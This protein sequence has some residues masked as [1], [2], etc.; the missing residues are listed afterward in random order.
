[1]LAAGR[2]LTLDPSM[3]DTMEED[4]TESLR[5]RVIALNRQLREKE[6]RYSALFCAQDADEDPMTKGQKSLISNE[7]D[8][9][10]RA[11]QEAIVRMQEFQDAHPASPPRNTFF[12]PTLTEMLPRLNI[13][14]VTEADLKNPG[15]TSGH[16]MET[17]DGIQARRMYGDVSFAEA[18]RDVLAHSSPHTKLMLTPDVYPRCPTRA[19]SD[20]VSH[21]S[22]PDDLTMV[23]P[24][25]KDPSD[26]ALSISPR[27]ITAERR[28]KKQERALAEACTDLTT[29]AG[30]LTIQATGSAQTLLEQ[31]RSAMTGTS[32]ELDARLRWAGQLLDSK[33]LDDVRQGQRVL[34]EVYHQ[35]QQALQA[36]ANKER[37]LS[38]SDARAHVLAALQKEH[39]EE[40]Q[41]E[42]SARQ[43]SLS[44]RRAE[45]GQLKGEVQA[46][47]ERE[48]EMRQHALELQEQLLRAH[49]D[50]AEQDAKAAK[51]RGERDELLA[52]VWACKRARREMLHAMLEAY[53]GTKHMML[54]R[55][56]DR[57]EPLTPSPR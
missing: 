28:L 3:N 26:L 36:L 24:E 45:A 17:D 25:H 9:L 39:M 55:Q 18:R 14:G 1:M 54:L 35:E 33:S 21:G 7:I 19:P 42:L 44:A 27:Q 49:A 13:K 6:S 32:V 23:D 53:Q 37:Q 11:L 10:K 56:R 8:G 34:H 43:G 46:M 50:R 30:S 20:L 5:V 15:N 29:L 4:E 22:S 38:A 31:A 48:E 12:V 57:S 41:L 16:Q 2:G 51:L 40:M 52:Q 47:K